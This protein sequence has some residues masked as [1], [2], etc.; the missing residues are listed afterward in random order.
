[1]LQVI[2]LWTANTERF[3][4]V[5][6]GVHDTE[7]NLMRAVTEGHPEVAPSQVRSFEIFLS[8]INTGPLH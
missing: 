1:M 3:C 4:E 2:I 7:E 8:F 5:T 6:A